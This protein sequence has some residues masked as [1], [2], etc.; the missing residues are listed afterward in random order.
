M[1]S[2]ACRMHIHQFMPCVGSTAESHSCTAQDLEQC[3]RFAGWPACCSCAY[4]CAMLSD[5]LYAS[6]PEFRQTLCH[7][8]ATCGPLPAWH[9]SAL[10]LL[11]QINDSCLVLV[12]LLPIL[13]NH[14]M[15]IKTTG[16][17]S[18]TPFQ[19]RSTLHQLAKCQ[20][21]Y[22]LFRGF[23]LQITFLDEQLPQLIDTARAALRGMDRK[24]I[25]DLVA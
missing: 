21:P 15:P 7:H 12:G 3:Q 10:F 17:L 11:H 18:Y 1:L 2:Y 20:C 23:V 9:I 24:P 4:C 6:S 19:R 14:C 5:R 8:H 25:N 13:L 22:K 16:L